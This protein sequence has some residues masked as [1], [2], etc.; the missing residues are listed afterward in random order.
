MKA[1][2]RIRLI[3]G[4]ENYELFKENYK[5]YTNGI[6]VIDFCDE[7]TVRSIDAAFPW[8]GTTQGKVF[9]DN[10]DSKLVAEWKN[11]ELKDYDNKIIEMLDNYLS[12]ELEIRELK[13]K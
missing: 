9:W 12:Q 7:H 6:C 2:E 4:N 3:I 10:L 1:H 5:L 13:K 8:R 11:Y